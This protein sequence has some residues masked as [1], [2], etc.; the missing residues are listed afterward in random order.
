MWS[1]MLSRASWW[2][3]GKAISILSS[4][5]RSNRRTHPLTCR[6]HRRRPELLELGGIALLPEWPLFLSF[7]LAGLALNIV[8][9]ADMTFI[10]ASAAK[11]G[12]RDGLVA[13]LGIGAGALFHV[14]AAAA[15]LS[16]ILA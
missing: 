5:P 8:P 4:L 1:V 12:R 6:R 11:G 10:I 3:S 2:R 14:V 16:A 15:G 9:G 13:A 7:A